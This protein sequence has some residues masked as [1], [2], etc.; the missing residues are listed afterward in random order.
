VLKFVTNG[1][2]TAVAPLEIVWPFVT[3]RMTIAG[4]RVRLLVD[5]GSG[6]LVLFKPR[7][8]AAVSRVPWR[9]DKRVQYAS[10][11]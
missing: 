3:V 2:D 4:E 8:P 11:N 10:G 6:D 9:G 7:R 5:T 1:R